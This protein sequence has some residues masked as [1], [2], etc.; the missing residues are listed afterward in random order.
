M[1]DEMKKLTRSKTDRMMGGVC[2]G[3]GKYLGVD[4]T[5]VRIVT[6]LAFFITFATAA[7]VYLAMWLI[8]PE[9]AGLVEPPLN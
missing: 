6:V 8:I 3:V 1:A 5:V 4:P 7:L 9:E 2:A